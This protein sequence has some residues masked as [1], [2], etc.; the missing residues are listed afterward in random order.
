[1]QLTSTSFG[2][3]TIIP[4]QFTCKGANSSPELLI[5]DVP[6]GTVSL[7]LIMHDPDAPNGDFLHWTIWNISAA[8]AIIPA[9]QVPID[10]VQGTNDFGTIGYGGPCPPSGTHRYI[11]DLFALDS[12]INLPAGASRLQ[13]EAAVQNHIL[14]RTQLIG[15]VNARGH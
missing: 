6:T 2:N 11:F 3:Q 13:L 7:A 4:D 12:H 14:D 1:M 5:S 10:A 9:G 15:L 8:A